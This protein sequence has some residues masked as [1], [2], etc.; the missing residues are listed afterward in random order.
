MVYQELGLAIFVMVTVILISLYFMFKYVNKLIPLYVLSI[1]L[2]NF[3]GTNYFFLI[4]NPLT[5]DFLSP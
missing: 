5:D 4:T 3:I 1:P 2:S